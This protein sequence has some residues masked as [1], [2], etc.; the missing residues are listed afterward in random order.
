VHELLA[1]QVELG[2][3][4][5]DVLLHRRLRQRQLRGYP[6][7]PAALRHLAQHVELP[8]GK[9][10][11]RRLAQ[12]HPAADQRVDHLRIDHRAAVRHLAQ[13]RQQLLQVTDAVLEQVG[14]ARGAV[15]E[16]L[17]RVGLVG[18]LRQDHHPDVRVGRPDRVRGVDAFHRGLGRAVT[19]AARA[20]RG[21]HP[22]VRQ[23][24]VG[25]GPAHRVEQLG[26]GADG[27]EHGHLP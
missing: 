18:V 15:L 19:A 9:P 3:D 21:R 17:E 20:A 6:R 10:G 7:V 8:R 25:P 14:Q 26:R 16:Q 23:H 13:G 12:S 4:R 2:E 5:V 24:R 1:G 11:Q 27:G 22:D